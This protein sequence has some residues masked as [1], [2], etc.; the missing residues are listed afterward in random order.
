[1]YFI[2]KIKSTN[3]KCIF[4][5]KKN[6]VQIIKKYKTS[7]HIKCEKFFKKKEFELKQIRKLTT[8]NTTTNVNN[9]LKK[10]R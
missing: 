1:M 10:S 4:L 7:P 2:G 9:D 5:I 6:Y 3:I 8:D